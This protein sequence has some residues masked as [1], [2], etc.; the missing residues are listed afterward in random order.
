MSAAKFYYVSAATG[1]EAEGELTLDDYEKATSTDMTV[2]GYLAKKYPDCDTR[3]GDVLTQGSLN[4]GIHVR[5]DPKRGILASTVGDVMTGTP[6]PSGLQ[7]ANGSTIV[8]PSTQGTTPATRIFFPEV[9]MRLMNE[10]L[11]SDYGPEDAIWASM[12]SET[13]L[14]PTEMFTQPL[15]NVTAPRSERSQAIAQNALPRQ[16]VSITSSQYSKSITTTSIGLQISEQAQRNTALNLVST[17]L[18]QQAQG[19]RFLKLWEDINA[20][21]AGNLDTA[22]AALS[23]TAASGYDAAATGGVM[24]Q[25]AWMKSLFDPTRKVSYDSCLGV[26]DTFLAIQKRI[27]RPVMFDPRTT[28]GSTGSSGNYGWNVEPN[29]LNTAV[30]IP[31]AMVVPDGTIPASQI[32]LFDSRFALRRV[33]NTSAQYSAIQDLVLQRAS[34]MRFD[35]GEMTYRLLDE[36]FK[37]VS[38]A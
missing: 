10:A 34:V 17:I 28:G 35:A 27:D 32:L 26:I 22:Q 25:K 20:V 23:V 5:G 31:K 15:I 37:L 9:I 30:D 19:E 24:T 1:K 38:F 18:L 29:I 7:L 11:V 8:S 13:E 14:I 12:I 36:A 2:S 4:L 3:F 6:R 21:V 16:L 33:V